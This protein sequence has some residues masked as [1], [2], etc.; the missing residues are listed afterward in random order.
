MIRGRLRV[1]ASVAGGV[2]VLFLGSLAFNA[3]SN[4]GRWPGVLDQ[5]RRYPWVTVIVLVPVMVIALWPQDTA[6]VAPAGAVH[7]E[8]R[9][10]PAS[11]RMPPRNATFTGRESFLLAMRSALAS[12]R[13][14]T[15]Q[16][17]QGMAGVGK[18]QLALEYAYR[19]LDEY[20]FVGFIDAERPEL[21]ASQFVVLATA[22]GIRDPV[23]DQATAAVYQALAERP[24]WLMI[25][26]N[27]NEQFNSQALLP[28]G[29]AV[30]GHIV[31]TTRY[32]GWAGQGTTLEL[33]V[34][35]RAESV[36]VLKQR[37][38]TMSAEA[39]NE[40]AE[41]LGDLPL[42]LTQAAAYLEYNGMPSAE[43]TTLLTTQ[44]EAMI[45][46]GEVTDRPG[47]AV[48]TLWS[49]NLRSLETVR[50]TAVA[51]LRL[52]AVVAPEPFPLDLLTLHPMAL[53]EPLKHATLDPIAWSDTVGAIVGRSLARRDGNRLILH[54]LVQ[55]AIRREMQEETRSAVHATAC[56]LLV[57]EAPDD[58][59]DHPT[60]WLRWQ[61]LLPHALALTEQSTAP[62]VLTNV[63]ALLRVSGRCI[64]NVGDPLGARPLVERALEIDESVYG[65]EHLNVGEDLHILAQILRDLGQPLLARPLVER[66]LHIHEVTNGPD[67]R[68]VGYDLALL[69][70]ILRDLGESATGRPFIERALRIDSAIHG[71]DHGY[72]ADDLATLARIL[73]DLG[74]L[75][76]AL[77]L[78][79]RALTIDE[80]LYGDAHTY[81]GIDSTIMANILYDL[82]QV[83]S[84]QVLAVRALAILEARPGFDY[85][86]T[87]EDRQF[88]KVLTSG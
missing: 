71:A 59:R 55:A 22:L 28:G 9:K 35:D 51:L 75:E 25:F 49:L 74:D 41:L 30:G 38:P 3:A 88:L 48:A 83:E 13:A 26:D 52:C 80:H 18:T 1:L 69:A 82:G 7:T 27:A 17:L 86:W 21:I 54:R 64:R 10:P 31:V 11:F 44:L 36:A 24:P 56:R 32:R 68:S 73:H 29:K 60:R 77:A 65:S 40:I 78:A 2:I 42:A 63:A 45:E 19:Y 81:V 47:V 46:R 34:F 79:R 61:E 76:L 15:V 43:Y 66:A 70:I 58:V 57:A 20:S 67:D 62:E 39:A 50:P 72:V 23:S 5:V 53:A 87:K 14:V 85:R 6:T 4:Q 84:A 8:I 12:H 37:V 33:D 16:A